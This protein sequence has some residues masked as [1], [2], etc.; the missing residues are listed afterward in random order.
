MIGNLDTEIDLMV[1]NEVE[2]SI[3]FRSCKRFPRRLLS[4]VNNLDRAL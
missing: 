4:D 1:V 2:Q 3:R